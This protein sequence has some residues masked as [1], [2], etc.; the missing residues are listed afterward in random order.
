MKYLILIFGFIALFVVGC[1][2]GAS[3]SQS[4]NSEKVVT[5]WYMRTV[6]EATAIDGTEYIHET[7]G[8]M[9]E[10]KES[11]NG[12]DRHDIEAFGTAILNVVFPQKEWGEDNGDYFSDYRQFTVYEERRVWTF[13]VKNQSNTVN[14]SQ[15]PLTLSLD[16][17]YDVLSTDKDGHISFEE[18]LSNDTSKRTAVTLVDVDNQTEYSYDDLQTANLSMDGLKT[19]TFRWVLGTVD[20]SDYEAVSSVAP[21]V[22]NLSISSRSAKMSDTSNPD[23]KFGLPPSF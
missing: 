3:N 14:L 11:Q 9:G 15:A 5:G 19:R 21:N 8:V 20:P 16:G 18:Q 12:K 6:A 4:V 22:E 23:D 2:S 13:Q 7:A 1:D 10:L 17:P